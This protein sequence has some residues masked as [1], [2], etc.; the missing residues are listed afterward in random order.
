MN[1]TSGTRGDFLAT[2]VDRAQDRAPVIAPRPTSLFEPVAAP[3][4]ANAEAEDAAEHAS[5]AHSFELHANGVDAAMARTQ[6]HRMDADAM[7]RAHHSGEQRDDSPATAAPPG[8][9]PRL[10]IASAHE[11]ESPPRHEHASHSAIDPGPLLVANAPI[12]GSIA[13]LSTS[14]APMRSAAQRDHESDDIVAPRPAQTEASPMPAISAP[15]LAMLLPNRHLAIA[16]APADNAGCGAAQATAHAAAAPTVTISIGRVEVR[17][18]TPAAQPATRA[19]S[20]R[21]PM[22]LDEYLA[23]KERTR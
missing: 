16:A 12:A 9:R 15:P 4:V 1:A 11:H 2:V 8:A 7:P 22:R 13:P 14:A 3:H 20:T 23:R 19:K 10:S 5:S 21:Q 18:S 17:A 6:P